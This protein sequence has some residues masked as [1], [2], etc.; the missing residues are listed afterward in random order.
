[1][2]TTSQSTVN[3]RP[4]HPPSSR[5][6]SKITVEYHHPS[7]ESIQEYNDLLA[8]ANL[9]AAAAANYHDPFLPSRQAPAPPSASLLSK[10]HSTRR[11]SSLREP[12]P[13]K[14][15]L[16]APTVSKNIDRDPFAAN[17]THSSDNVTMAG[18]GT[19]PPPRPSRANTANLTDLFPTQN[20]LAG[21]RVSDPIGLPPDTIFYVDEQQQQPF[22]HQQPLPPPPQM[23]AS[24]AFDLDGMQQQLGY[25]VGNNGSNT[26]STTISGRTRSGTTTKS[27][28]GMFNFMSDLLNT[29]K[30]PE[31]ST[32]YDPVHLTHVGFNSSTGEFTGL[33]KE[34]QQLLQ[35][36]GISKSEQEK[37]PQAVM[38]IVKFYQEGRGDTSV[39]DKMGAIPAPQP[40]VPLQPKQQYADDGF[41]NP[42]SSLLLCHVLCSH[43]KP[44]VLLLPPRRN[45][46]RRLNPRRAHLARTASPRSLPL[47][48]PPPSTVQLRSA[49]P[50]PS[51]TSPPTSSHA[52]TPR[53]TG[54]LRAQAQAR[55]TRTRRRHPPRSHRS[56]PSPRPVRL[57][58]T[59]SSRRRLPCASVSA[60]RALPQRSSRALLPRAFRRPR[61]G[62]G[63]RRG[64]GRRRATRTRRRTLSTG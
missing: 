40:A 61:A 59:F 56:R 28:K 52:P 9:H 60:I 63:R 30:R 7:R 20:S 46:P 53:V 29:S 5:R 47:R 13:R 15:S 41:Q 48:S 6:H 19:S 42:V 26:P 25:N 36:S 4:L 38:E 37:N 21:H 3:Q 24:D 45:P 11:H 17:R 43:I 27:K 35:E 2:S 12:P 49:F 64:G 50:D 33:P 58:Q 39:W 10:N 51:R 8:E 18:T 14:H 23:A 31:I 32:P 55:R 16:P 22:H 62:A 1:M 54:A 57:I 44:S 34:W